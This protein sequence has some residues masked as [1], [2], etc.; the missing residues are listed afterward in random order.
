MV[1]LFAVL[2]AEISPFLKWFL[3]FVFIPS[4]INVAKGVVVKVEGKDDKER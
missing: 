4:V 1:Q 2:N 3:P